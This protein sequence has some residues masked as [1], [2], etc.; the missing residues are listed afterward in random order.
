VALRQLIGAADQQE[1]LA[2]VLWIGGGCAS[3]KTTIARWLAHRHDL[4][5]YNSD[6]HTWE[7]HDRSLAECDAGATRWEALS[8]D[9][10]W[11][12]MEPAEMAQFSLEMNA[13]RFRQMVDDV[14]ALPRSPLVV[15]EGT[16]LL[17]WLVE[18]Y[19]ASRESAVWLIPS[20]EFQQAR[21]RERPT[22]TWD[23]TSDPASALANRIERERRVADLI[24]QAAQ[25]RGFTTLE[26]DETRDL[27]TMKLAVEEALAP[28][29][30]RGPRMGTPEERRATRR[31]E[32]EA[33]LR[34]VQTYLEREPAAGTA[35]SFACP[36]SCECGLSGCSAQ[37]TVSIAQYEQ[38]HSRG[39]LLLAPG[40]GTSE[41]G[42]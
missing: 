31:A 30:G 10:R 2:H 36:F 18:D 9:E 42:S 21:L 35:E 26:V 34:Q 27:A 23:D 25:E 32:N 12:S 16:P 41:S 6:A 4:G 19:L 29:L 11:L 5:V 15:M 8:P 20:P 28:A 40:H 13:E 39:E 17:P 22:T 38:I 14:R 24:E 3:G 7:H 37:L 33:V 1:T